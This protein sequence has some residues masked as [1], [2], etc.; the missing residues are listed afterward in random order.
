MTLL[1]YSLLVLGLFTISSCTKGPDVQ[2]DASPGVTISA[3]KSDPENG[4][5]YLTIMYENFGKDTIS[6]FKYELITTK[7]SKVDTL[8]KEF[9]PPV[10]LKPKDRHIIPRG[11]GQPPAD[12]DEV[13]IGKVW[14]EKAT[15]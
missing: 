12:F 9:E 5:Q 15:H 13:A 1:R 7:G 6:R 2:W 4:K 8:V 14:V 10:L 11:I 3:F